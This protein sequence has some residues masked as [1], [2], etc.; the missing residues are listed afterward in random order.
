MSGQV[1]GL[2]PRFCYQSA[3]LHAIVHF[4][5]VA[6]DPGKEKNVVQVNFPGYSLS[7]PC[8]SPW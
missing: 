5:T 4:V 7:A 8:D 2:V 3:Y 1:V 6:L